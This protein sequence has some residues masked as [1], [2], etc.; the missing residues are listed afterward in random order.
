M[1]EGGW[2]LGVSGEQYFYTT[3]LLF[4]YK[5]IEDESEIL[6]IIKN[7]A[8]SFKSAGCVF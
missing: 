8:G 6:S 5:A 3:V 7:T 2:C 4:V 1:G